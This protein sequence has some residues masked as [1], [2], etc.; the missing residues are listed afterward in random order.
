M[1]LS[2]VTE[3]L[4]SPSAAEV[5]AALERVLASA[6]FRTSPQLGAFL[7][8]VVEAVLGGRGAG[9]KGYTIGVE[10]LG[11]DR[12]FDPQLDPIVRVEATRLRRAMEGYYAGP[13]RD[14]PVVIDLPRGSYAPTFT[15]RAGAAEPEPA[16]P[17]AHGRAGAHRRALAATLVLA[18][19]A[20]LAA[21]PLLRRDGGS[22][23][24]PTAA[25]EAGAP[26]LPR[27]NGMPT[28][29]I[30]SLR[31]AG[32]PRPGQLAAGALN[33][34]LRDAFVRFDTINVAS[35]DRTERDGAT[36]AARTDLDYRLSG[37]LDYGET[38]TTLRF[39]LAD[40]RDNTIAW[41][42]DFVYPTAAS[43]QGAAEDEIVAALT[44]ALLQSYGVIRARDYARHLA[45]AASD[46]R[47]RCV[48]EAAESLRTLDPAA[49]VRARACLEALT[50]ADPSFAVGLEFLAVIYYREDAMGL[51]ARA[52]DQPPLDRALRAARRAV[53]LAPGSARA[54]QML[55][56][57]QY[58]RHE[59]AAAFVAG[60]KAM[61]LNPYDLLTVAE[62][63]GRLI[64]TGE[65]ERGLQMLQRARRNGIVLPSWHH[66]YLFLGNYLAGNIEEA[67]FQ[68]EQITADDY[69]L[70][71]MARAIAAAQSGNAGLARRMI[72]RLLEVQPAWRTDA[73]RLLQKSI[74][75]PASVDRLMHDLAAAGLPGAS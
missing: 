53:E 30:E 68:A 9:L 42:R 31:V 50:S 62:Y 40:A 61:S 60:D 65:V 54:H 69:P 52:G 55:F 72:E 56:V 73:R 46:P 49:H 25:L 19:L 35:E 51:A 38:A 10:A 39:Q 24:A 28:I 23:A 34:K 75:D 37:S 74:Y 33:E 27:R 29:S 7:R 64:M 2:N 8:F 16:P 6:S 15:R 70:G 67:A 18:A 36:G 14:D 11:R 45:S 66:Y 71:L 32:A 13:G 20:G 59:V 4:D 58:A 44:N 63:G 1:T 22:A 47:Y 12:R 26:A 17:S 48:L 57:V 5:E 41:T 21:L 3:A 43:G